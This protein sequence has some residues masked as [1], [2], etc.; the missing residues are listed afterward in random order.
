MRPE[1]RMHRAAEAKDVSAFGVLDADAFLAFDRLLVVRGQ[2]GR[3]VP[4]GP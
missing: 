1:I 2:S 4:T 3:L